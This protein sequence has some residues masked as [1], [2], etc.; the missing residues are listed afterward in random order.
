MAQVPIL[1]SG[2]VLL[3]HLLLKE[4][5]CPILLKANFTKLKIKVHRFSQRDSMV[6]KLCKFIKSCFIKEALPQ[7]V[8]LITVNK[9]FLPIFSLTLPETLKANDI[10]WLSVWDRAFSVN[11]GDVLFS[12]GTISYYLYIPYARHYKPR[13]V[14]FLP[15]FQ[16]PFLCF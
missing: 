8:L 12:A 9:Y 2:Q 10:K 11:F 1:F 4:Q 15:H 6:K 13:L 7:S 16:R 5:F 14:Y 3:K